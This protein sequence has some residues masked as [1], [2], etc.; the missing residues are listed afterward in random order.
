MIAALLPYKSIAEFLALLALVAAVCF[1]AHRF[2]ESEQKIG[3]DK[4]VAE[5]QAKALIAEEEAKQRQQD[6]ETQLEKAQN[7]AIQRENLLRVSAGLAADASSSLHNALTHYSNGSMSND[8]A[9]AL[10][11]ST[12][13][14]ATVLDECQ[15]NYRELAAKADRHASDVK[16]L[17]DAWPN[18]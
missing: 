1:G 7:E 3:Y 8:T 14:L 2:L 16:T 6:L 5:Y 17:T 9:A 15:G 13:T 10:F 18:K 12:A 11:K 4:A